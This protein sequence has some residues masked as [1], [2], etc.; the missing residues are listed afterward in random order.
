MA[1]RSLAVAA[2]VLRDP[3]EQD[4]VVS[5]FEKLAAETGWRVKRIYTELQQVWGHVIKDTSG[6]RIPSAAAKARSTSPLAMIP[7][8]LDL[9]PPT[10]MLMHGYV[11]SKE[12]GSTIYGGPSPSF[13]NFCGPLPHKASASLNI[14]TSSMPT[15][16][17]DWNRSLLFGPGRKD[18][19]YHYPPHQ[20]QAA[21]SVVSSTGT[22]ASVVPIDSSSAHS[23]PSS[24]PLEPRRPLHMVNPLMHA[25]FSYPDHP[26]KA[27]YK[28]PNEPLHSYSQPH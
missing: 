20:L 9:P 7:P 18:S 22:T 4:E 15:T 1:I 5:L 2:H 24:M 12:S 23:S 26:Y 14:S 25:D 6:D 3:R 11:N 21:N 16:S 28:P 13:S 17:I 27:F 10:S 8:S 19:V